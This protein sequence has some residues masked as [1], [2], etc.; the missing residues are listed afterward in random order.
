MES[1]AV[2]EIEKKK[3]R[4]TSGH[5]VNDEEELQLPAVHG[6]AL[7]FGAAPMM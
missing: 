7:L 4:E 6:S 1:E 5:D 3:T 2:S